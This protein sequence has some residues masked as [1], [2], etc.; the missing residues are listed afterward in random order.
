M[1]TT[2]TEDLTK[3]EPP[4]TEEEAKT[5]VKLSAGQKKKLKKQQKKE[6]EGDTE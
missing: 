5:A 1:D 6:A 2:K 3:I 4:S